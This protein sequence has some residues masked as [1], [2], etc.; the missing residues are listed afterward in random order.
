MTK[1]ITRFRTA[2]RKIYSLKIHFRF[3]P[4]HVLIES[5]LLIASVTPGK[6]L[7]A[8]FKA[9]V[10]WTAHGAKQSWPLLVKGSTRRLDRN[11]SGER[12]IIIT[13]L[14][15]KRMLV[16]H[17]E[18]KQFG[19]MQTDG[20]VAAALDPFL[21]IDFLS[22]PAF[23]R[24]KTG[25]ETVAGY[26]CDRYV[27]SGKNSGDWMAY[28]VAQKLDSPV[29]LTV[30]LNMPGFDIG[31]DTMEVT[32]IQPTEVSDTVFQVPEGYSVLRALK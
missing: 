27:F 5:L 8:E 2:L 7:A 17:V 12:E 4:H 10:V 25:Q 23:S 6:A 3:R 19:V 29:K 22:K 1:P 9:T 30:L 20:I 31:W 11:V 14:A 16:L 32:D 26:S 24:R 21:F 28:D 18:R 13:D 15:A